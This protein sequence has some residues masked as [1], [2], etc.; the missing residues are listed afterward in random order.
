[1]ESE[2][3]RDSPQ[4]GAT[5]R[6]DGSTQDAAA[7]AREKAAGAWSEAKQAA[8]A[9]LDEQQEAAAS[10]IGDFAGALRKAA[11]ESGGDTTASLARQ[12]ADGLERV[13]T[14][15]RRKDVDDLLRDV[16]QFAREQPALFLG[17]SVAAGFLAVRFLKSGA[18]APAPAEAAPAQPHPMETL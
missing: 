8:R 9:R 6:G 15:L 12:A 5:P 11:E 17:I 18:A 16:Q 3:L 4:H 10:G 13:A 7:L 2:A 1:M 14:T